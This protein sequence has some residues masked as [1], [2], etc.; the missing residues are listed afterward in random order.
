MRAKGHAT[1]KRSAMRQRA[2]GMSAAAWRPPPCE[3]EAQPEPTESTAELQGAGDSNQ[4][5][6]TVAAAAVGATDAALAAAVVGATAAPP[7]SPSSPGARELARLGFLVSPRF[8]RLPLQECACD[9]PAS[10]P[11]CLSTPP[12][13][14][15]LVKASLLRCGPGRMLAWEPI[16]AAASPERAANGTAAVVLQ[17]AA[18]AAAA[19]PED[20]EPTP[21]PRAHRRPAPRGSQP[22]RR[23][24]S[25]PPAARRSPSLEPPRPPLPAAPSARRARPNA[26]GPW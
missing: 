8:W 16:A 24:S 13:P 3:P 10:P 14:L 2:N 21:R 7:Q 6:Q 18:A 23:R 9:G 11:S 12:T 17:V 20:P 4:G 15:S 1:G 22:S 19:D 26:R 5:E 25:R